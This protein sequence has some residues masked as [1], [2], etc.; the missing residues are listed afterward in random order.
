MSERRWLQGLVQLNNAEYGVSE[1]L[2]TFPHGSKVAA[3][4]QN[5][6]AVFEESKRWKGG[7]LSYQ[8]PSP[9]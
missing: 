1:T 6:M 9:L 5:I 3:T 4:A 8:L 2:L 7:H